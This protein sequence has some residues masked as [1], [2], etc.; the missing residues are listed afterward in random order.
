M[1]RSIVDLCVCVCV[2]VVCVCV[3][4]A[5]VHLPACLPVYI[6][7]GPRLWIELSRARTVSPSLSLPVDHWM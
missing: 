3:W 4:C 2:C 1:V 5:S 7:V 6:A